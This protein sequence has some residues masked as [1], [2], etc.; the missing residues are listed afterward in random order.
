MD[1]MH[2]VENAFIVG[3]VGRPWYQ[4]CTLIISANCLERESIY[5]A[6]LSA[7]QWVLKSA[8]SWPIMGWCE[9][10]W[11]HHHAASPSWCTGH[12]LGHDM[13]PNTPGPMS[14]WSGKLAAKAWS[15]TLDSHC[16][17]LNNSY[18]ISGSGRW[19]WRHDHCQN[20]SNFHL[21]QATHCDGCWLR[22]I[23]I[24]SCMVLWQTEH[25]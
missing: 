16:S 24:Q 3:A 10:A 2:H 25:W 13:P 17:Y 4:C 22:E 14:V 9:T 18:H 11:L 12:W 6:N 7:E 15:H 19:S 23:C 1:A 21:I 5:Q 8:D 20:H